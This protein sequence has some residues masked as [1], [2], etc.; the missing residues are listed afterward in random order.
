LE[1]PAPYADRVALLGIKLHIPTP[2][3]QIM[4]RP[5]LTD[6]MPLGTGPLLRLVL[7]SAPAGF[8][9]TTLLSQWLVQWRGATHDG[10]RRVAWLSLDA[11]DSDPRRFL[12]NVLAAIQATAPQVG[13]DAAA[14]LRSD[15]AAVARGVLVDLI[16]DLDSLDGALVLALDD[17]HVI[18]S[19]EVHEAV[20]F[21]L[22]HL[23][24][25]ASL[26]IT[27]RADPPPPV[28]RLRTR[29]ELLELR[30]ADLRF[31]QPEAA[32]FLTEVMGVELAPAHVDALANRT[33]GWAAGLQLAGLSLR[34]RG[35]A[36]DF[37]EAFS[38]SHRFVLDYLV[39]EVLNG[40]P[41]PVRTFLLDTAIL[42]QLTGPLCDALTGRNDG[43]DML[44]ALERGNVFVVP[45][46]DLRRWY[47]YHHL[48]ADALQARLAAEEPERVEGLHRAAAR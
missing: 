45:L 42:D 19:Q 16:N 48:F 20:T 4:S 43:H 11:E 26:A 21:L 25:H 34:D 41:Q 6:Q 47:R 10:S 32:A 12:A 38:G 15:G 22:D 40:Q 36:G 1:A 31:T 9:K 27:T 37:I 44:E 5:R 35:D 8:G 18:E 46:D 24:A 33:E 17:Y 29:G 13:V 3:R 7:V 28:T 2:R 23:P 30:A 39:E 14:L